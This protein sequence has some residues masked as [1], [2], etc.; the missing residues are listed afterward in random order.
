MG[1]VPNFFLRPMEP[2]VDRMVQRMGSY[3]QRT[4]QA[5]QARVPLREDGRVVVRQAT[6]SPGAR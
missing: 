1:V 5:D 6:A 4:V 3:Q 2:A